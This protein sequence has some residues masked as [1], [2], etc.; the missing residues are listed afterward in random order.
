MLNVRDSAFGVGVTFQVMAV[1]G[2]STG[3][4]HAVGAIL[5]GV[6]HVEHVE[7]AGAGHLYNLDRRWILH[8]QP[9]GQIGRRV[10]AVLAAVGDDV[11]SCCVSTCDVIHLT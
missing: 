5:D 2:Q 9:A 10:G 3:D 1:S 6:Q 7:P 11:K 4:H 8:A